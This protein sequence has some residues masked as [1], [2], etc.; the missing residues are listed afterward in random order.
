[1]QPGSL[2]PASHCCC[3]MCSIYCQQGARTERTDKEFTTFLLCI[4]PQSSRRYTAANWWYWEFGFEPMN[5]RKRWLCNIQCLEMRTDRYVYNGKLRFSRLWISPK[6]S[7]YHSDRSPPMMATSRN[8]LSTQYSVTSVTTQFIHVHINNRVIIFVPMNDCPR[9]FK[10]VMHWFTFYAHRFCV[11]RQWIQ[12][13]LK[14]KTYII[15]V[16]IIW[17]SAII[18]KV[19]AEV[20]PL[21]PN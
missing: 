16:T 11:G 3:T 4:W 6:P 5:T 20:Y 15:I 17:C 9:P 12:I 8:L 2:S 10:V 13:I 18:M 14:L 21:Y 19:I 1:M 7:Y